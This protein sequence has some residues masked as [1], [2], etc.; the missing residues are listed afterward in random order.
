MVTR[1]DGSSS[2]KLYEGQIDD[3]DCCDDDI[4]IITYEHE[5]F[6]GSIKKNAYSYALFMQRE[7]GEMWVDPTLQIRFI[8]NQDEEFGHFQLTALLRKSGNHVLDGSDGDIR[9]STHEFAY[10]LDNF[11]DF[12]CA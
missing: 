1:Q 9:L 3:L 5:T 6:E 8:K 10:I 2:A 12:R 7:D 11:V 4:L